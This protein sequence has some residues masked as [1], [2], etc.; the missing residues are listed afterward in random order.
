M[1]D[2]EEL[3]RFSKRLKEKKKT[4]LSTEEHESAIELLKNSVLDREADFT[5][6]LEAMDSMPSVVIGDLTGIIWDEIPEERRI[7]FL[8]WATRRDGEKSL[9]RM[10][11]VS[12]S[13]L[14]HDPKVSI[15]LL[16]RLVPQD[17]SASRSQE[18]RQ[19]LRA[20]FLIKR[21]VKLQNLSSPTL[22][23]PIVIR[24]C[25]AFLECLDKTVPWAQ[26]NTIS[27]ITAEIIGRGNPRSDSARLTLTSA[28]ESEL[29]T[30]PVELQRKF[31]NDIET[32]APAVAELFP[33]LRHGEPA[34]D[35]AGG[36]SVQT[37]GQSSP[38]FENA[39]V[40]MSQPGI[41]NLTDN[42]EKRIEQ[43]RLDLQ[44]YSELWKIVG[45]F[46]RLQASAMQ[47]DELKA[48]VQQLSERLQAVEGARVA[49]VERI[50]SLEREVTNSHLQ[51]Q[52]VASDSDST[53]Q[54]R[55]QLIAQVKAHA[56]VEIEQFKNRLGGNLSRLVGDLPAKN[57][58][59]SPAS[60]QVLL[61]Q[62]HQF[63]DKLEE[64]GVRVRPRRESQ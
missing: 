23:E 52:Q 22:S 29:K 3:H 2:A 35:K 54:E 17:D 13:L 39:D 14:A 64:Q 20:S 53:K 45:D 43:L 18:L 28:L 38:I 33:T 50:G 36:K 62:Y 59:L 31:V 25:R 12:A 47:A 46:D 44:L 63:L 27:Q 16:E 41:R 10:A 5:G 60:S 48:Q 58:E 9:R 40:K 19:A 15:S 37:S 51:L 4:R 42:I 11:F 34:V 8:R 49:A 21:D 30:W 56:E 55:D 32:T 26:H 61:R 6:V 1:A 24:T 57:A 7:L